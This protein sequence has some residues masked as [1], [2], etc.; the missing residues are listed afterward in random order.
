MMTP[1]PVKPP[2]VSLGL[3]YLHSNGLP[4]SHN[5][6]YVSYDITESLSVSHIAYSS[7]PV[8][9]VNTTPCLNKKQAK[10]FLL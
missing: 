5:T 9:F 1:E 4:A 2:R 6:R 8:A 7:F 10:L 3:L